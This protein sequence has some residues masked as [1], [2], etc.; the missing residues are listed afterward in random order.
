MFST[1]TPL[2][3]RQRAKLSKPNTWDRK[4]KTF[5]SFLEHNFLSWAESQF[6]D[7]ADRCHELLQLLPGPVR[8]H[9]DGELTSKQRR[10]WSDVVNS[11]KGCI[12]EDPD[13][14][15][16]K[17]HNTLYSARQAQ[18]ESCGDFALRLHSLAGKLAMYDNQDL[19]IRDGGSE[20]I[21]LCYDNILP[22][23]RPTVL[24]LFYPPDGQAR[25]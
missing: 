11:V 16:N 25:D 22:S 3:L 7:E 10:R 12:V 17:A 14:L 4:T 21:R 8:D 23:L 24:Q 1:T 5:E 9:V 6:G 2:G 13:T 19:R 18:D 20:I 15:R